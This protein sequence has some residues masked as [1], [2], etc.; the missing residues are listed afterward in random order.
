M[1]G[2]RTQIFMWIISY[3]P[4]FLIGIYRYSYENVSKE[5][6]IFKL[7]LKSNII[8]VIIVLIIFALAY[9]IYKFS[10]SHILKKAEK[11]AI[12]SK[13]KYSISKSSKLSLSDYTFFV[14]T[15]ILPLITVDFSKILNLIIC[16]GVIFLII[17]LLVNIEYIIACPL[18]IFSKYKVW[19]VDLKWNENNHLIE[20][21]DIIVVTKSKE[22]NNKDFKRI[23]LLSNVYLLV[24]VN[25]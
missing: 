21:Q 10:P 17:G 16:F 2:K 13:K 9:L 4:V 14:L 6:S 23:K 11:K 5:I 7:H 1:W 24:E 8:D 3:A 19:R 12:K 20:K 18:L 25:K 22:F 15:L